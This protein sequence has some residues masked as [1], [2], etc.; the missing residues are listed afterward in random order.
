MA[1]MHRGSFC[2]LC[3]HTQNRQQACLVQTDSNSHGTLD[4]YS[5]L[6]DF[7]DTYWPTDRSS[8]VRC[9]QISTLMN[10]PVARGG[11]QK[12]APRW[13]P[14]P[15]KYTN[16]WSSRTE[17]KSFMQRRRNPVQLLLNQHRPERR[18]TKVTLVEFVADGSMYGDDFWTSLGHMCNLNLPPS[19]PLLVR[20]RSAQHGFAYDSDLPKVLRDSGREERNALINFRNSVANGKDEDAHYLPRK[21]FAWITYCIVS[22]TGRIKMH[23]IFR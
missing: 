16:S 18:Y 4:R 23:I 17:I 19:S 5:P 21:D 1:R 22:L 15:Q 2:K 11:E 9:K 7:L 10:F 8:S 3:T 12:R 13:S 20:C 6:L 14:W